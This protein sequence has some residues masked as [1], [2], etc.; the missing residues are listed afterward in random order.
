MRPYAAFLKVLRDAGA[1]VLVVPYDWRLSNRH[2]AG[3][4]ERRILDRWYHGDP[5]PRERR[6]PDEERVTFIGH[7]MGGL[8]ARCFLESPPLGPVLGRRLIT[9]GTPHRGAPAAYLHLIGRTYPFPES[10]FSSWAHATLVREARAAG[11]ALPGELAAQLI[12]GQIQTQLVRFMAST[13]ELLPNYNFVRN[14]GGTEPWPDTYARQVHDG[15]GHPAIT[16]IRRFRSSIVH[17]RELE[18]WLRARGLEYHFLAG[19]GFPTVLG[20]DRGRDRLLTGREGDGT[21]PLDSARLLPGSTPNL[22]TT[23]LSGE[24]DLGH[25]RLCQRHDVQRYC[26][27]VLH[28]QRPAAGARLAQ[29]PQVEDFVDMARIILK[30]ALPSR[31]VVL[32]VVRLAGDPGTPLIDTTTEP[33]RTSLRRR[34]KNPPRHLSSP[35]IFEVCSPRLRRTFR[36]VWIL[37]NEQAT[38]PVG[39]VLFLPASWERDIRFVTLNVGNLDD[40]RCRN[41]HHA[42][43]QLVRWV[44]EQPASWRAPAPNRPYRQPLPQYQDQGLQPVPGLLR[45]PGALPPRPQGTGGRARDRRQALLAPA[46]HPGQPLRARDGPGLPRPV[47]GE[48][49]AAPGLALGSGP[50]STPSCAGQGWHDSCWPSPGSGSSVTTQRRWSMMRQLGPGGVPASPAE[51]EAPPS[52]ARASS[53]RPG[54][55]GTART[56]TWPG[57]SA[58][59]TSSA[60][61]CGPSRSS[62]PSSA[63]PRTPASRTWPKPSRRGS[64]AS[65]ARGRPTA[66]SARSPGTACGRRSRTACDAAAPRS[67]ASAPSRG[68]SASTA[69]S[70]GSSTRPPR[71]SAASTATGTARPGPAP[72][73]GGAAPSSSS[74]SGSP[75]WRPCSGP[76]SSM[77][78]ARTG[79]A[80]FRCSSSSPFPSAASDEQA[81]PQEQATGFVRQA[82]RVVDPT[83]LIDAQNLDRHPYYWDEETP[84]HRRPQLPPVP[85]Q[86]LPR[87]ARPQPARLRPAVRGRAQG[88]LRRGP[89]RPGAPTGTSRWRWSGSARAGRAAGRDRT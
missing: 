46:L 53:R 72:A 62:G 16:I 76:A 82:S 32:S 44:E 13:F 31:G 65:S 39:G 80:G 88:A 7:S 10:P 71:T 24:R 67:P 33:S 34:L 78:S 22:H 23:I 79:S 35:E 74:A 83:S 17:E 61:G 66:S 63:C 21:V 20:Y 58:G 49:L 26:L 1:D 3:L 41:A 27:R 19:T 8:V 18:G 60:G 40:S 70:S 45:R 12:P 9:I 57:G 59:A 6:R 56:G 25:Q 47:A 14:Q 54:P 55:G 86:Q 73:P 42:E 89:A 38:H 50:R 36:Y 4:L 29:D 28:G 81:T 11:A 87:P 43:M 52:A 5:P 15:T 2:N 84:G 64:R 77:R 48:R 51:W 75:T 30:N 85:R 69:V 68:R 37:S